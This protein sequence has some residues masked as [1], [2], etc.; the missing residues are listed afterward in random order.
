MAA[1]VDAPAEAAQMISGVAALPLLPVV[2]AYNLRGEV[3]TRVVPASTEPVDYVPE[4]TT[5]VSSCL[6]LLL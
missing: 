1:T 6:L 3:M 4:G 2:W 5:H